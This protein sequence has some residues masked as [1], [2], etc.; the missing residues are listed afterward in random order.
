MYNVSVVETSHTAIATIDFN[1][2]EESKTQ[3]VYADVYIVQT[4]SI[5]SIVHPSATYTPCA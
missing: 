3:S 5:R 2:N 4:M 1:T